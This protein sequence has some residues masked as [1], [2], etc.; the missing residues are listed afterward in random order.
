MPVNMGVSR[1]MVTTTSV[2]P[3]G[4][5]VLGVTLIWESVKPRLGAALR[6]AARA[7]EGEL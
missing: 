1:V 7:S 4:G 3:V 5:Q 6:A 2:L